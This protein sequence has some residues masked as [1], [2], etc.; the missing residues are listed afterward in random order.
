M[1]HEQLSFFLFLSLFQFSVTG[2]VVWKIPVHVL[3]CQSGV[4]LCFRYVS[5]R[6]RAPGEING[7]SGNLNNCLQNVVYAD[8]LAAA[9]AVAVATD[10]GEHLPAHSHSSSPPSPVAAV[11]IPVQEVIV[12]FDA[13]MVCKPKF[14]RHVSNAGVAA[15]AAAS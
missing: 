11:G 14:F 7:K 2:V 5:G 1:H 10:A 15:A 8:A 4:L 3:S 9:V 13:D 6:V 12:V